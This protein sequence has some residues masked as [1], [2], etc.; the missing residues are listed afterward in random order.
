MR[1][2]RVGQTSEDDPERE[3]EDGCQ[4]RAEVG[5]GQTALAEAARQDG[6]DHEVHGIKVSAMSRVQS[7]INILH[8]N[9]SRTQSWKQT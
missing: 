2:Q 5:R 4:P 8:A 1:V 3:E 6:L 9:K 7:D